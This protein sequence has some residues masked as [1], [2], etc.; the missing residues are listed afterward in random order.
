[1][2]EIGRGREMGI[3][4]DKKREREREREEDYFAVLTKAERDNNILKNNWL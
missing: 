3:E 4:R 1:M 2:R